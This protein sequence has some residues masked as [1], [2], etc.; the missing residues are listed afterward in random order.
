MFEDWL[1]A[2]G[3]PTG[4]EYGARKAALL[5]ASFG[6]EGYRIYASLATNLREDYA[7]ATKRM[8][9]HFVQKSSTI[10]QRAQFT[11]RQQRAGETISQ[12]VAALREMAVKCE[13]PAD[14]LTERVRDQLIAWCYSDRIRE[15]LLQEPATKSLDEFVNLAVTMERAMAEAPA[16]AP[17]ERKP[18]NRVKTA[19]QGEQRQHQGRSNLCFNCCQ[20]GHYAKSDACPARDKKCG[21]CGEVGHFARACRQGSR[22]RRN[23]G[24]AHWRRR[25]SASTNRVSESDDLG[26]DTDGELTEVR[27]IR[28]NSISAAQVGRFK[29]VTCFVDNVPLELIVDTGAKVSI[30]SKAHYTKHLRN[31]KLSKPAVSL[32]S[33]DGKPISCIG[34]CT[35]PVQ[36]GDMLLPSFTFYVTELGES[37]MGV[38]LFDALGGTIEIC[39]KQVQAISPTVSSSSVQLAQFPNLIK[40]FGTLKGFVHTP[41]ID[42]SVRPVQQKFWHP[43]ISMRDKISAELRRMEGDGIIERVESSAWTSNIVVAR[44]KDG[45]VRLCVNL[46]DVNKALIPERYPLPTMEELTM[47]VAGATVFSKIDLKWGY[48][49]L[50]ISKQAR[51]LT[52]FVTHEGV[53]QFVR[54]PFGLATGPSAF[55]RVIRKII[56]GIDGCANILDDILVWGRTMAEH[57]ERLRRVLQRLDKYNAT[58]RGDKCVIGVSEV[59]FNGHRVSASGILPLSSNIK[60]LVEIPVPTNQ[61]Q[62]LRFMCTATY[63][64]KFV[65][66]FASMAEPLRRLLKKDIAWSWTPQCQR[67]FDE[68]K[69]AVANPPVLAHF[70]ITADTIV[71]CDASGTALGACLSQMS[72]DGHERPVA[73]ASRALSPAERKYSASERE[74]LACIWACEKWNF[75]LYGRKFTLVTDHQ[76]LK[77]LLTAGGAGHRPLR[78]HRWNDRLQQYNFDVLYRPGKQNFAADCL[79]RYNEAEEASTNQ[80]DSVETSDDAVEIDTVFGSTSY[81]VVDLTELSAESNRDEHLPLIRQYV[82]DGWPADKKAVPA[83]LQP[84]YAVRDDLSTFADGCVSRGTRAVIPVT[85]RAR[86]L[87]LA[88]EGHPGVVRMKQR[89]RENIW[90]PGIDKDIE[91]YVRECTACVISGKSI[92]PTPLPAKRIP[93]PSGPWRKVAIDIAGEFKAAPHHQR[94]LIVAIDCYSKWPEVRCTGNITSAAVID[95]LSDLFC[96]FGTIEELVSDNG[97]QFISDELQQFLSAHGVRHSKAALYNPQANGEVERFN[98]VLKE[99]LKAA[100]ADGKT[101]Q[102]GVRQTLASYRSTPQSTTGVSPAKLM[103]SF[104]MRTQLSLLS[105]NTTQKVQFN[106][107]TKRQVRFSLKEVKASRSSRVAKTVDIRPGDSVRIRI[108]VRSHK[109]S[110]D[111]SEPLRVRKANETTVW[112]ENGQRWSRRRCIKHQPAMRQPVPAQSPVQPHPTDVEADDDDEGPVITFPANRMPR[113]SSRQHRQR[114]LGPVIRF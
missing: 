26:D 81:P 92:R 100:L 95:F 46:K 50:E 89:C 15:R 21:N 39:S 83:D 111:Y 42:P 98:R 91:H 8:E 63:Y 86:M 24:G 99:G 13:F 88:H 106:D 54:L 60:A 70:D 44:K 38:D 10:F 101:F 51:Q 36:L 29:L 93:S 77:T 34:C 9:D 45:G 25:R 84:Y 3:F 49:Q 55:Q 68:I 96:R 16:L 76:A 14:Q 5:R 97:P 41:R 108:P 74:A 37:M 23:G 4:D 67:A 27:S 1:L 72:T 64:L 107:N 79:S 11:R 94:F 104:E 22:R 35:V 18:V 48:L 109:L 65:S 112:L 87:E 71:A 12:Y 62:L 31:H 30:L 102:Q 80:V 85:L 113:R 56:D 40:D 69:Q 105:N 28:I 20:T 66:E 33:F 52:A 32:K 47:K 73:F 19:S 82:I 57:D 53:F 90:W 7:A 43:A 103:Y 6:T 78:L 17:V 2:I 114:D 110:P 75:Y 61:K 58:V 59:E